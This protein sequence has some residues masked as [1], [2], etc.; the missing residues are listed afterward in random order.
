MKRVQEANQQKVKNGLA[1]IEISIN[2]KNNSL[3]KE[4]AELTDD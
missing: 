4:K 1:N 2:K 3:Q